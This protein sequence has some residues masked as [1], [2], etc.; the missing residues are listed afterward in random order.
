MRA[1]F[2]RRHIC[3]GARHQPDD[4]GFAAPEPH[5]AR[6]IAQERTG[7]LDPGLFGI[8][9]SVAE[10][11]QPALIVHAHID[12]FDLVIAAVRGLVIKT[13]RGDL[14]AS[15]DDHAFG[16]QVDVA[17]TANRTLWRFSR[18]RSIRFV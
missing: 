1:V 17:E 10:Y 8:G 13:D 3:T 16:E 18:D 9:Q 7:G 15:V 12:D 11:K 4:L 2:T 14:A 5:A 6:G